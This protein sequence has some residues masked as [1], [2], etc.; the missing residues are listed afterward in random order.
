MDRKNLRAFWRQPYETCAQVSR[1]PFVDGES[2]SLEE[3]S[4]PLYALAGQSQGLC[5]LRHGH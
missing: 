3:I 4:D 1:V 5:D 2:I